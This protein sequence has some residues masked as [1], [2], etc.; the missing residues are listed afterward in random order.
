MPLKITPRLEERIN[1]RWLIWHPWVLVLAR[2]RLPFISTDRTMEQCRTIHRERYIQI[3]NQRIPE[4]TIRRVGLDDPRLDMSQFR[5]K[6]EQALINRS[7]A[8]GRTKGIRRS[9]KQ[10]SQELKE[11]HVTYAV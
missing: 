3:L 4:K 11:K 9:R 6:M 10:I 7:H 2:K 5:I 1:A 8:M